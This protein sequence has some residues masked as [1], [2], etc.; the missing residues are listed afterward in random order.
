MKGTVKRWFA[1]KNYGFIV[2]ADGGNDVFF[3]GSAVIGSV[4]ENDSVTYE[5][6]EWKRGPEGKN[7]QKVEEA[8][9]AKGK[10]HEEADEDMDMAA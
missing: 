2:P 5:I 9:A 3:H 1:E 8:G 4:S 7:V 6:G 10:K